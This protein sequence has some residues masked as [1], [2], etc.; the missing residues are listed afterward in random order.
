MFQFLIGRLKTSKLD[1]IAAGAEVFQF[2]IGRLKTGK[3]PDA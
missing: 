3:G 1:G 2:L